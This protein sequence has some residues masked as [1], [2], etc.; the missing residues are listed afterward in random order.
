MFLKIDRHFWSSKW[1]IL[2]ESSWIG[3]IY[4]V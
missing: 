3:C 4:I 1:C 2:L